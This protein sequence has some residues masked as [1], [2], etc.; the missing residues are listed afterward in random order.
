M[1]V[2]AAIGVGV[3]VIFGGSFVYEQHRGVDPH[4]RMHQLHS[5]LDAAGVHCTSWTEHADNEGVLSP[6]YHVGGTCR[7]HDGSQ[8]KIATFRANSD[9]SGHSYRVPCP[10]I[11]GDAFWIDTR[12]VHD[13]DLLRR[14]YL[15]L[16]TFRAS[17]V[18]TC[19]PNQS[20]VPE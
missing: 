12:R 18:T 6:D 16:E 11:E 3:V 4:K 13:G 15:A 20:S 8:L 17:N 9:K 5:A 10:G 2:G 1:V 7:L 14:I 19:R